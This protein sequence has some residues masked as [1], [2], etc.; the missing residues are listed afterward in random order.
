MSRRVRIVGAGVVVALAVYLGARWAVRPFYYPP[1]GMH[2]I[3]WTYADLIR[4]WYPR[5][6]VD[7]AQLADVYNWPEAETRARLR[8]VMPIALVGIFAYYV[9]TFKRHENSAA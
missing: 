8:L 2:P 1:Q 3:N 4:D 6:L 9:F 5:H 7:P